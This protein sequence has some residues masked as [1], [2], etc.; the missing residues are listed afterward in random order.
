MTSITMLIETPV[1]P[2]KTII[3]MMMKLMMM[4]MMMTMIMVM[5]Q[6]V[7][8]AMM[9][10]TTMATTSRSKAGSYRTFGG[11]SRPEDQANKCTIS[12][13]NQTKAGEPYSER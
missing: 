5:M 9:M 2:I 1:T 7:M 6:M 4:M 3:T 12:A 13:G 11:Q 10:I 8:M